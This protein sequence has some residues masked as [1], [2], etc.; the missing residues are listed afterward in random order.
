M[1]YITDS[2]IFILATSLKILILHRYPVEQARETNGAIEAFLSALTKAGHDIVMLT[3]RGEKRAFTHGLEFVEIPLSLNRGSARDKLV[4][5][6]LWCLLA[7]IYAR[8]VT[9]GKSFHVVYCDDSFPVYPAFVKLLCWR[10][11]V[12]MRLGDLQT[13]YIFTGQTLLSRVAFS[14]VHKIETT[15]WRMMNGLIPISDEFQK[16][17]LQQGINPDRCDVVPES[18]NSATLHIGSHYDIRKEHDIPRHK[19]LVVFHGSVEKAKGLKT[20]LDAIAIING[21]GQQSLHFLI[22]GDGS[23][24]T[25]LKAYA[26]RRAIANTTFTGWISFNHIS[27]VISQ[28]DIGV[29]MRM[30]SLANRFI[31]TMAFIQYAILA[32]PIVAPRM[33]EIERFGSQFHSV[34]LYK[35]GSANSLAESI[36]T[37]S[38]R[39]QNQ[40]INTTPLEQYIKDKFHAKRVGRMLADAVTKFKGVQE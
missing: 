29:V 19:L 34:A 33:G 20:L 17:I 11:A 24:L 16:Y 3:Y 13:G 38:R 14:I 6:L 5:S 1:I 39:L 36:I 10:T 2:K 35:P 32:K 23:D 4:K 12:I 7:P 31:I 22:V 15:Y 40:K 26:H 30:N 9:R 25:A 18:Y 21:S 37:L 28:S 8:A 27:S